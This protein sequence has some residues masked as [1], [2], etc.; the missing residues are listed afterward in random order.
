M[1]Y[2]ELITKTSN[3]YNLPRQVIEV[4]FNSPFKFT[5]DCMRLEDS[6]PI[7]LAYLCKIKL[8]KKYERK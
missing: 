6:K 3:E 2:Q 4:V 1:N 8:K 5:K 7:M